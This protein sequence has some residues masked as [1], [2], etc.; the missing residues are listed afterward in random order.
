MSVLNL[1]LLG[2][3]ILLVFGIIRTGQKNKQVAL[4]N[5]EAAQQFLA[6]NATLPDVVSL[7]SGLQYQVLSAVESGQ[8]PTAGSEVKVHYHGTL[9]SGAVFDSSVNR[10]EPI[11]FK[12]SQV[13]AGW[14]EGL[15]LMKVG[16]KFR[17][18]IP[19]ELAYGDRA[20][21][22]IA[23]GSLLIFEVELLAVL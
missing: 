11:S 10:G 19:A 2:L 1:A 18:Y 3:I 12:L 4:Q 16:E 23:P 13:I 5:R 22:A 9:L 6:H 7:P 17:F 20:A 15:Q 8:S 14:T 21:G